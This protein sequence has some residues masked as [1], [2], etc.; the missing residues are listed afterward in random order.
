MSTNTFSNDARLRANLDQSLAHASEELARARAVEAPDRHVIDQAAEAGDR[1]EEIRA[2]RPRPSWPAS[3]TRARNTAKAMAADGE[4]QRERR[5]RSGGAGETVPRGGEV[6]AQAA[7]ARIREVRH[8]GADAPAEPRYTP[9]RATAELTR[10]P[11]VHVPPMSSPRT[12]HSPVCK[13]ART[14]MPTLARRRELPW[15]SGSLAE[16]RRTSRGS[17]LPTCSPRGPEAV[18][19]HPNDGVVRVEQGMPVTVTHLCGAARRVDDVGEQDGGEDA[20]VGDLGAVAG[21]ELGD[22]VERL[23]PR[24]DEVDNVA[25]RQLNVFR[26]RYVISDVLAHG[27]RDE[28][29]VGVM[30]DKGWHADGR[31][32]LRARLTR[33]KE[34]I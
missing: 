14:S 29:V 19:L 25:P 8:P 28:Q 12:S 13:P 34:A 24:F 32:H 33:S 2:L 10:C 15:R 21:E 23:A 4:A 1:A 31:K 5:R 18:E 22:L 7:A 30:E 27:G 20:I 16:D 9:S 17:R 3:Q 26:A 11:D 6:T